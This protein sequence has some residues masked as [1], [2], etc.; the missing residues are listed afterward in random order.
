MIYST[1]N[2]ETNNQ[3]VYLLNYIVY[4]R[5]GAGFCEEICDLSARRKIFRTDNAMN[6]QICFF[7][8][9]MK[10]V[11]STVLMVKLIDCVIKLMILWC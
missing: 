6:R 1:N 3:G 9:L 2:K 10:N 7:F 8:F 4:R 11:F 5:I